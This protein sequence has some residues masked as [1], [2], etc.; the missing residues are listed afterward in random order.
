M[1]FLKFFIVFTFLFATK[2]YSES[3]FFSCDRSY[4]DSS[5]F[6]SYRAA[7]SWYNKQMTVRIDIDKQKG[8]YRGSESNV[9][10]KSNGK[11]FELKFPRRSSKGTMNYY[12][13]YFLPNGEVHT[14]LTAKAG[15][16]KAGGAKYKCDGWPM[17]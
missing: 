7:E 16:N 10:V 15:F 12:R 8:Y 1:K 6:T 9:V 3:V 17:K 4:I 2:A 11:R 14:E 13:I 5:G